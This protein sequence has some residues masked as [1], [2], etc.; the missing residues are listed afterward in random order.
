VGQVKTLAERNQGLAGCVV[1]RRE[2]EAGHDSADV[3]DANIRRR[4]PPHRH[5]VNR[6][7]YRVAENV[8][9]DPD[10]A[11]RR[12]RRSCRLPRA[13]GARPIA[14]VIKRAAAAWRKRRLSSC[15][16][17]PTFL[18]GKRHGISPPRASASLVRDLERGREAKWMGTRARFRASATCCPE[19]ETPHS[20]TFVRR[21]L[22]R[23]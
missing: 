4:C 6:A 14:P 18:A 19:P 7:L 5:P 3:G 10:I 13:H 20:R 15:T 8:E 21:R 11:H 23:T 22:L 9:A 17:I 16:C 1:L 2:R 12:W